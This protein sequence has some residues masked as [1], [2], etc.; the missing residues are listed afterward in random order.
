MVTVVASA[1]F[2][3]LVVV[4]A[5]MPLGAFLPRPATDDERDPDYCYTCRC[6]C[7]SKAHR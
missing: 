3:G 4:G 1:L 7:G 6:K 5:G 2:V